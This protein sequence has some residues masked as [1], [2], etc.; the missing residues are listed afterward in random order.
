[1]GGSEQCLVRVY[2]SEPDLERLPDARGAANEKMRREK[3]CPSRRVESPR[4]GES[5]DVGPNPWHQFRIGCGLRWPD[6][7]R[8][9]M[10]SPPHPATGYA[11]ARTSR[12]WRRRVG[13]V[14]NRTDVIRAV[15]CIRFVRLHRSVV[16]GSPPAVLSSNMV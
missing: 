6:S 10:A 7:L 3:P 8:P 12:I 14:N 1:M 13:K 16:F 11:P 2:L 15:A 5:R 9:R 4:L